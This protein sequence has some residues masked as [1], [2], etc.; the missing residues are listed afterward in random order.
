MKH[1][2]R[3]T[4][5]IMIKALTHHYTRGKSRQQ[6]R[7]TL[8]DTKFQHQ[9]RQV[10]SRHNSCSIA[11]YFHRGSPTRRPSRNHRRNPQ[12]CR[13]LGFGCGNWRSVLRRKARSVRFPRHV[14][15]SSSANHLQSDGIDRNINRSIDCNSSNKSLNSHI[16]CTL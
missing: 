13:A 11:G 1:I 12:R 2:I 14:H 9:I 6:L 7:L 16:T 15:C 4:F 3:S 5:I 10:F 8:A